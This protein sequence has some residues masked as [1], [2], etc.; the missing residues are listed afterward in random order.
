MTEI[1]TKRLLLR[2]MKTTDRDDLFAVFGD[3]KAMQYWSTR[4]HTNADQTAAFI[5]ETL[6]ADPL[7]TADFAIELDGRVVG[8]AGFWR[9]PEVGYLLHP[10]YWRQ[11]YGTEALRAL[12]AY[13]FQERGLDRVTADVD[14][15]NQASIALLQKLGFAETGREKNTLQIGGSWF[16]SIYFGLERAI[17]ER[18]P[19]S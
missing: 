14:P 12:I 7:E 10:D 1:K 15:D 13:G 9:L 6:E 4:P 2:P 11:G 19:R 5:R 18:A 17:W 3:P 8:K 16:D